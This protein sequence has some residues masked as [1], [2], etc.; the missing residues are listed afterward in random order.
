M[1]GSLPVPSKR[2]VKI[3]LKSYST[4]GIDSMYLVKNGVVIC[5][6]SYVNFSKQ[7][8]EIVNDEAV[9]GDFY[10]MVCR[11]LS[12]RYAYSNPVFIVPAE[13]VTPQIVDTIS[14]GIA[15]KKM[16]VNIGAYPNPGMDFVQ[17]KTTM[18][19]KADITVYDTSSKVW[20]RETFNNEAE[21]TLDVRSLP[22]GL[23]I[24]KINENR[25][26]LILH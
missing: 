22:R 4:E 8:Q 20:L 13:Q 3:S 25:L 18:P 9:P 2:L 12:Y 26:K 23:Y 6:Y 19:M 1:G 5:G 24:V 7:V 16:V 10:R 11:D 21:K 17:L 14:T 15:D